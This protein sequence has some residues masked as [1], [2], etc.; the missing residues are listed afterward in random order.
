MNRA[1]QARLREV[2]AARRSLLE[3]FEAAQARAA[4]DHDRSLALFES[5]YEEALALGALPPRDPLE[6][7]DVTI[8]LALALRVQAAP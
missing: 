8:A 6:G 2:E 7:I 1:T 5:L 3:A 4:P